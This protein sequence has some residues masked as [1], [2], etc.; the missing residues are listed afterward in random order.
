MHELIKINKQDTR[1]TSHRPWL[2]LCCLHTMPA[3]TMWT[4][5]NTLHT[6]SL[7]MAL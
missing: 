2:A 3:F 7:L 1:L 5:I 4:S 6:P